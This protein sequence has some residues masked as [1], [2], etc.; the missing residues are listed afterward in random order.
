MADGPLT[1]FRVLDLTRVLAGPYCTALL[2]DLGAEVIKLEPPGGDEY[3]H[4]GPF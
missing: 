1:G 2:A 3:R 4:I